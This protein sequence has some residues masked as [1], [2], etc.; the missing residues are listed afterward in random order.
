V[1]FVVYV[2]FQ[3]NKAVVH[4]VTCWV[5]R[6]RKRDRTVNGFWSEIFESFE[7]SLEFAKSTGRKKV[8]SCAFCVKYKGKSNLS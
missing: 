3:N 1:G 6:H 7:T 4:N 8:D 5:Y 2:N